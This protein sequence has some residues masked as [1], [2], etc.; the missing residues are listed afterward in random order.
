VTHHGANEPQKGGDLS[1]GRSKRAGRWCGRDSRARGNE[2]NS[3]TKSIKEQRIDYA[4]MSARPDE[5]QEHERLA[6]PSAGGTK[7]SGPPAGIGR[8]AGSVIR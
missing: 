7:Q 8:A 2:S 4:Q 3:I 5:Q 6:I 1:F